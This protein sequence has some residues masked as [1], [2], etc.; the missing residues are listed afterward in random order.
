MRLGKRRTRNE[1]A[2]PPRIPGDLRR[3]ASLASPSVRRR[4]RGRASSCARAARGGGRVN[5]RR[6]FW[7]ACEPDEGTPRLTGGA[8]CSLA[9]SIDSP[10]PDITRAEPRGEVCELRS[11]SSLCRPQCRQSPGCQCKRYSSETFGCTRCRHDLE[12][13]RPSAT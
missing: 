13:S 7:G 9:P 2:D 1:A 4:S 10:S 6:V 5:T 8:W 11:M 12:G 3:E